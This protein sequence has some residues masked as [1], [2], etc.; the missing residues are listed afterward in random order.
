VAPDLS[1]TAAA[2]AQLEGSALGRV[3]RAIEPAVRPLGF[4]WKIGV[5]IAASFAAREVFVTT[6]GTIYG[7]SDP[8]PESGSLR[9]AL[10]AAREP[11]TGRAAYTPL[12][13]VGLM[14]FYVFALMCMSTIAI[15]VRETG[16]GRTGLKW[17]GVQFGYMLVLA[18]VAAFVVRQVGLAN[19]WGT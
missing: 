14:V 16:G 11:A 5:S 4:D 3:G 19:G 15:T 18:W 9:D 10:R 7:V 8:H 6:M 12:T 1:P 2:E 17:A 13:A